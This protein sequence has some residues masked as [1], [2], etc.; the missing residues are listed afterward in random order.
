MR[1]D[2]RSPLLGLGFLLTVYALRRFL[3]ATCVSTMAAKFRQQKG[4]DG[5]LS[6]LNGAIEA[7]DIARE[8]SGITQA[9]TAFDSV[10]ALLV[11]IRVGL[12]LT[13]INQPLA[14][15]VYRRQ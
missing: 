7:L 13:P 11:V 5:T 14:N 9:K 8:N 3:P 6:S 2:G 1:G 10:S 15:V 4:T 12:L